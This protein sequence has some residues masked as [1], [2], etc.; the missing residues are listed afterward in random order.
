LTEAGGMAVGV[1][2]E[3]DTEQG[4]AAAV[5]SALQ[6]GARPDVSGG[7]EKREVLEVVSSGI[8]VA[9]IVGCYPGGGEVDAQAG[10]R[11]DRIAEQAIVY[12]G[13]NGDADAAVESDRIAAVGRCSAN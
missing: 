10:V 4:V 6:Q 13:R 7:G 12:P 5:K 1:G 3:L 11:E 2:E 9:K 8:D